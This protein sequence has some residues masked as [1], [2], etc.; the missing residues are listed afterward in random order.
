MALGHL[1]S[2]QEFD[3]I[4][5]DHYLRDMT[6]HEVLQ[7]LRDSG[8]FLPVVYVTGSNE[9]KI[10]IDALKAGAAD[11]VIKTVSDDFLPL[12][13]GAIEQSVE[14]ARLRMEKLRSDEEIRQAKDHAES[15]LGEVN[16]RVANS[17]ALVGSLLRLQMANTK[18]EEAK[19]ELS[20]TQARIAAIAGMHRSLYTTD[21]VRRVEMDRYLGTLMDQ[22]ASSVQ[23]TDNRIP[24]TFKADP[25]VMTSDRA[26]SVGMVLTELVTNAFKYAYPATDSGEIR[27]S[28]YRTSDNEALLRVEDDG[29]GFTQGQAPTGTGLGSRIVKSMATN[30]GSGI[31]YLDVDKGTVAEVPLI[32]SLEDGQANET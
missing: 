1:Q 13:T 29:I 17:L 26:V 10:A 15:L 20:H 4:V 16:H 31:R 6:G 2:E 25:I 28:L 21:D 23:R 7:R 30:L 24:V 18:S 8:I 27:V 12:L 32:I 22:I 5:L 14:N 11:Y 9:A 3:A 19:I